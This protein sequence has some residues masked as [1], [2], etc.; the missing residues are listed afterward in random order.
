MTFIRDEA[1]SA[2]AGW[3]KSA[4]L[5]LAV[6]AVGLPVNHVSS[7]ALLLVVAVVVFTGT[8]S[9]RRNAWFAAVAIVAV[10]VAGQ[11]WLSP[12]RIDEGP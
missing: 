10:A 3:R 1:P 8:V 7:Y 4:V 12:P 6:A 2:G 11:W 5:V 9:A